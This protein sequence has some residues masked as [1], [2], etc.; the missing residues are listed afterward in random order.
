MKGQMEAYKSMDVNSIILSQQGVC[1]SGLVEF[2][3]Y[4]E[5]GLQIPQ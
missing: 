2:S 3:V 1:Q 4:L 5:T